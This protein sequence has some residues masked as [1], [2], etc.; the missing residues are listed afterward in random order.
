MKLK[1]RLVIA[2]MTIIILPVLLT[3]AV[4]CGFAQL[5][6]RSIEKTYGITGTTYEA[7][8]N[9]V[10]VPSRITKEAYH[11]LEKAAD[12]DPEKLED[13][14]Y[15][16]QFLHTGSYEGLQKFYKCL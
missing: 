11:E 9:S 4:F 2:F 8:L 5:Q 10:Q 6:I 12:K 3:S 16:E 14:S 13:P 1:T 15:L 7:L